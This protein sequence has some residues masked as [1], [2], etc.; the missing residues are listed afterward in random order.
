MKSGS[1]WVLIVVLDEIKICSNVKFRH[2]W[3]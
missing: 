3:I 1:E 2:A